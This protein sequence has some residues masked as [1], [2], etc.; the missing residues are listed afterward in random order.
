MASKKEVATAKITI[1]PEKKEVLLPVGENLL[2]ALHEKGFDIPS[3]CNG[4]GT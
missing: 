2:R 3:P 4:A 1:L